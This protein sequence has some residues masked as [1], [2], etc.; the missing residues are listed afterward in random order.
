[1]KQPRKIYEPVREFER[2]TSYC[3]LYLAWRIL[4]EARDYFRTNW[5]PSPGSGTLTRSRPLARPSRAFASQIPFAASQAA[6]VSPSDAEKANLMDDELAD[7]LARRAEAVFAKHPF[8][9][10]RFQSVRGRDAILTAMRHWLA[11]VLAKENPVRFRQLPESFKIGMP[12]PSSDLRPP[13]PIR[14]AKGMPKNPR[15]S[16]RQSAPFPHRQ[17]QSRFTSAATIARAGSRV[18][19]PHQPATRFVHGCELL[20]I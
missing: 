3:P 9:Q 8:W 15:S 20:T 17:S 7:K 4:D 13:S 11:G 10:R 12:L 5:V 18:R 6:Q 16:G 2:Q 14:W 1:M 19:S